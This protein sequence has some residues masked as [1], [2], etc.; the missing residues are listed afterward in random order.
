MN[1]NLYKDQIMNRELW[2]MSEG[3]LKTYHKPYPYQSQAYYDKRFLDH[4]IDKVKR[5][6]TLS[7]ED[8]ECLIN[9]ALKNMHPVYAMQEVIAILNG[10]R[11][12]KLE[13]EN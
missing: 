9:I 4:L 5:K 7:H 13:C 12:N 10:K 1:P 11:I 3:D 6:T 2:Q 8:K